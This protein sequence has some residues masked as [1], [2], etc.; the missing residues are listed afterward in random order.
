MPLLHRGAWKLQ[1]WSG[2]LLEYMVRKHFYLIG[3]WRF[4]VLLEESA[5]DTV[6]YFIIM[7]KIHHQPIVDFTECSAIYSSFK[8]IF[9]FILEYS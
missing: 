4:Y 9:Y 8:K 5:A 6:M 1:K 3:E 2:Q 7:G